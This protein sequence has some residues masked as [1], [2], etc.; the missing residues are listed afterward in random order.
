[1][2]LAPWYLHLNT[3][4]TPH[5]VACVAGAKRGGGGGRGEGEMEKGREPPSPSP[6]SPSPFSL[7]PY[8]L[9]PTP[10][11]FRRLLRRLSYRDKSGTLKPLKSPADTPNPPGRGLRGFTGA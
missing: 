2:V 4:E 9:P 5:T 7:P 10:Y 6:Q 3:I 8:P 11:P 1:M